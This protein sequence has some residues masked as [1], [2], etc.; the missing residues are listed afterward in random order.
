M[1]FV[2][3]FISANEVE[4]Y[5]LRAIDEKFVVGGTNARDWAIDRDRGYYLRNVAH[6][7][8]AEQEVRNQTKWSFYWKGELLTLR[9]DLL[10]SGGERRG[11]GW[12]R[13]TLVWVN[14]GDGLPAHLRPSTDEFLSDLRAAL[15]AHNGFGG[16]FSKHTDYRAEID[17][18][19]GCAL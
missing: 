10:E 9:L 19:E 13:W 15:T 18:S 17:V 5:E 11:A 7:A 1:P 14:G 3:E 12:S 8:G 16:A 4:Q 6:G 2:S